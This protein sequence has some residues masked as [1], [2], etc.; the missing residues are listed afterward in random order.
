MGHAASHWIMSPHEVAETIG[1]TLSLPSR[2]ELV[3]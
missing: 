1:Q 3:R 2:I